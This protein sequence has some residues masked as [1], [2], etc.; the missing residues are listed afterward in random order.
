M[1]PHWVCKASVAVVTQLDPAT[2]PPARCENRNSDFNY[3]GGPPK[4]S[5]CMANAVFIIISQQQD[6][7]IVISQLYYCTVHHDLKLYSMD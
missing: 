6:T 1:T 2:D 3:L 7:Y 4:Q 5:L